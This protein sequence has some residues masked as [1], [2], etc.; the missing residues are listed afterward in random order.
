LWDR[1]DRIVNIAKKLDAKDPVLIITSPSNITYL[2]GIPS[3]EGAVLISAPERGFHKLLT[4]VLEYYRFKDSSPKWVDVLS[5]YRSSNEI[6]APD[7][8]EL[9]GEDYVSAITN[10]VK[11]LSDEVYCDL[12]GVN[13]E[14]REKLGKLCGNTGLGS[15]I[16]DVRTVK[17]EAE[18]N[19]IKTSIKI[20]E[21]SFL[22]IINNLNAGVTELELAGKLGLELRKHGGEKEAFPTIIAFEEDAAYPHAIPGERRLS[23]GELVLID[24]GV[25]KDNYNS[26]M[27]R[28][29]I[30][31]SDRK[32]IMKFIEI[33]NEAVEA[34]IDKV[35]PGVK[36]SE[37]DNAARKVLEKHGLASKFIHGLG[38][39]VG[40]EV[41]EAPYIRPR[42]DSIIEKGMIFTIE[43][44]VYIH[45]KF[46]VRI[47]EMVE[48]TSRGAKVLTGIPRILT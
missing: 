42:S 2:T 37:I 32:E 8:I 4:N 38:H 41:H 33:V 30:F 23:Q 24:W 9:A 10:L 45:G 22:E 14:T 5:F 35:E 31:K 40:V 39:G 16:R 29:F 43:P 47:E 27:T 1:P 34:A 26:D 36:A 46:G 15:T 12:E 20:A 17:G 21:E 11:N 18:I 19:A 44:G 6:V 3:T 48:V 7:D 13:C 25:V 28:T